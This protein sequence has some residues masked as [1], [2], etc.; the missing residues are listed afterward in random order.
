MYVNWL[1]GSEESPM[2]WRGPMVSYIKTFTGKVLWE[3]ID[4][5]IIDMPPELK[6]RCDFFTRNRY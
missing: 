3:N 1:Y 6:N 4:F 5:L 2:I